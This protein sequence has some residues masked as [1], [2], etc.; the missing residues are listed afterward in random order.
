VAFDADYRIRDLYF[1]HVGQENHVGGHACRFG[2][3]VD[4]R[5]SWVVAQWRKTLDYEDDTLVTQVRLG[6]EPLALAVECRDAV[7]FHENV[8]VREVRVRNL[9]GRA[10]VVKAV[11]LVVVMSKAAQ[12]IIV[13]SRPACEV[14]CQ[15]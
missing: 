14:N 6:H 1:P 3:F 7:D 2:F 8:M 12:E 4:G 9:A 15:A 10:R 5:F 13:R 11:L